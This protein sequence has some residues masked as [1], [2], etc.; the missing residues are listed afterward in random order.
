MIAFMQLDLYLALYV[1]EFVPTQ[2]L[3]SWNTGSFSL[4]NTQ[5]FGWMMGLNGILFVLCSLPV[6]KYFENWSNRNVLLVSNVLEQ[7]CF[8][9]AN[10][11]YMA[12]VWLYGN[13]NNWRIDS[14]ASCT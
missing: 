13:I 11:E 4:S 3:F 2:S 6:A 1:K 10:D 8:N 14:F 9:R 7:V 12:I 5:I